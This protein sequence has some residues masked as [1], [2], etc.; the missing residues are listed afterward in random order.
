LRDQIVAAYGVLL[1]NHP[2]M[3]EYVAADLL[4]WQRTEWTDRLSKIE[5]S[6]A[7]LDSS[8]RKTIRRFLHGAATAD[9]GTSRHD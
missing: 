5:A 7:S 8:A 4:A 6:D 2:A 9:Q 1:D 3:S